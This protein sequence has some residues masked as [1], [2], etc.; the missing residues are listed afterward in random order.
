MLYHLYRLQNTNI[1]R[2]SKWF[3]LIWGSYYIIKNI[4]IAIKRVDIDKKETENN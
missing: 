2:Y 1:L 3:I 4:I